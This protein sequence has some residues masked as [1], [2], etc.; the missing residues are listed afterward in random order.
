MVINITM[1]EAEQLIQENAELHKVLDAVCNNQPIDIGISLVATLNNYLSQYT[2]FHSVYFSN[3]MKALKSYQT[4]GRK[5]KN[6]C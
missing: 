1:D 4:W 6:G 3:I 2:K 5:N